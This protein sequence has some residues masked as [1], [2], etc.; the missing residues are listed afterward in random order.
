[1]NKQQAILFAFLLLFFNLQGNAQLNFRINLD[2]YTD[3]SVLLASYYGN[4]IKLI[5]T[6]YL[7]EGIFSFNDKNYPVGIYILADPAKKKLLEFILNNE[8]GFNL[9][10]N[11]DS[12]TNIKIEGSI[13]NELF[14]EYLNLRNK[15]F[16]LAKENSD[17]LP[18]D[19][20]NQISVKEIKLDSLLNELSAEEDRIVE[21]YPNL[22]IAQ[23]IEAQ[24]EI[25]IPDSIIN[26]S[27]QRYLYYKDHFW[28]NLNLKDDRFLRTPIIDEKLHR[29]F[30]Q[31]VYLN[32]DSTIEAI[33]HVISLT[34]PT[35]E[36]TSYLLWYFISK[37]Q[38]PKYM[39]FD[40][41]FVHLVD[42]Y[43]LKED[44]L[45]TTPSILEKLK[46][47]SD[48]LKPLLIGELAP[49][50]ILID[51]NDRFLS[52]R[53]LDSDY[54]L[55]LFWDF[56]CEI[57]ESEISELK[58]IIDSTNYNISVY[59]VNTNKDLSEWK[60]VIRTRNLN[61][62][63]VNGTHSITANFHD[64]YD[65]NGTPRLFLLDQEK[66]IMAKHFKVAQL[67]AIIENQYLKNKH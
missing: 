37:Y 17:S 51:T 52:F 10:A 26:D 33:D 45:N 61:W 27:L 44:V 12:L 31:M 30:D 50:L 58:N 7:N 42:N 11:V 3:S 24:S 65:I 60:N 49:N 14:F 64:L 38:N 56:N 4:K 57:C 53:N 28:D 22:F 55:L 47:R 20:S 59:A 46:E 9:Q 48:N 18:G 29:Y 25:Q 5:D 6:S 43:F 35:N 41:V 15:V 40:A 67:I 32:P 2:N 19:S 54:L 39:G 66:K 16:Q 34:R 23:L 1:M 62:Y 8:S 21:T 13:E 36:L 63:N